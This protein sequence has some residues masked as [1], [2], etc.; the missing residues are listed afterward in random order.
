MEGADP[1]VPP[2]QRLIV[3]VFNTV[4]LGESLVASFSD[5]GAVLPVHLGESSDVV[6]VHGQ[7]GATQRH[8]GG[9]LIA[10]AATQLHSQGVEA[11]TVEETWRNRHI[12]LTRNEHFPQMLIFGTFQFRS[13]IYSILAIL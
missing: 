10:R 7:F 6:L 11:T 4:A 1:V 2:G 8:P 12:D 9:E 13:F 5:P 3:W